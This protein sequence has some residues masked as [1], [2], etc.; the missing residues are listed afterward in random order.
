MALEDYAEKWGLSR[1]SP[2]MRPVL[3]RAANRFPRELQRWTDRA[4]NEKL[5]G[6][7]GERPLL[8]VVHTSFMITN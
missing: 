3:R 6:Q 7:A 5:P 8:A 4:T 1:A 2:R